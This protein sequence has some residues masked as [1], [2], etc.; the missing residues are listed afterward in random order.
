[1]HSWPMMVESMSATNSRRQRGSLGC[2]TTSTHSSD[3]SA[4]RAVFISPAKL[5]SAAS[6]SSIQWANT[7][8]GSTSRRRPR[9][10]SINL[11]SSRPAAISVA[12]AIG[13]PKPP[14]LLIA[15]PT[16][17]GKSALAL[18]AAEQIKGVIVNA[19]SAQLYRDLHV[20]SAAPTKA[21]QIRAEHRLYGIR[22]G[23]DPCS[24]ADWATM[25]RTEI[26][27]V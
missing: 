10:R 3:S 8:C 19:D 5:R 13:A 2:M 14:V 4:Q 20:L 6:P 21:E 7:A 1:M 22:D 12:M 23:A 27:N 17:S 9:A 16:A 24:A 11:S 15:G 18:A 25:A 26:A